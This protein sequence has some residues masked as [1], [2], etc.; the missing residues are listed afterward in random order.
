MGK[1]VVLLLIIISAIYIP[2][3]ASYSVDKDS[4][5]K[6]VVT[7]YAV[8]LA[9]MVLSISS[10][11]IV[12]ETENV[13]VS[14]F[15]KITKIYVTSSDKKAVLDFIKSD[16][17]FADVVV[18]DS[19]GIQFKIPIL[20]R[21]DRYDNRLLTYDTNPCDI[22]TGDK[23]K[24]VVDN[25]AQ[26]RI[27]NPLLFKITMKNTTNAH[28]RIDDILYSKVREKL[29]L[30][31]ADTLVG[32]KTANEKLFE[33]IRVASNKDLASSGI[34]IYDIRV[35]HIMLPAENMQNIYNKMISERE[36]MA[37]KYRSEGEEEYLKVTS[38][39]QKEA[40]II[41]AEAYE[42]A[43]KIKGEGD[44]E[45]IKI[46]NN[47]FN[48]DPEFYKFYRTL[49]SYKKTINDKTVIVIPSDSD[50]AKYLFNINK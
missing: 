44:A 7:Q 11:F 15:G 23:K 29:S 38:S 36:Q 3:I 18:S 13:V 5:L 30:T 25:F 32:D 27:T 47:V 2:K 1:L 28:V 9:L 49:Q 10:L 40:T 22:I 21:I 37:K 48:R 42:K 39:A 17:Q 31:D 26:W 45:A 19:R 35:K 14:R 16:K 24:L 12:N 50:F 46:Y 20:D 34:E 8:L 6:S 33:D 43:Q 41:E 4:R